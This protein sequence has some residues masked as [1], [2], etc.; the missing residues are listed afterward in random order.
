MK[1]LTYL[2]EEDWKDGRKGKI[3][4]SKL[5]DIV[6]LR[7]DGKKVGYWQL[8]ADRLSIDPD[9]E[10]PMERGHRLEEEAIARFTKET[11]KEVD[12]SLVILIRDDDETIAVSPDGIISEYEQI[13]VK[14]LKSAKH[15]EAYFTQKVPKEYYYQTLQYFI[16]NDSLETLHV[17]MYDPRVLVKDYFTLEIRRQDMQADVDQ[18]LEYERQTLKEINDMA[19]K[20]TFDTL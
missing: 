1:I 4:G 8:L 10:Y 7:G 5:G 3:T 14:C 9:E 16:V 12:T 19:N 15:L 20:L 17:V 2:T 18:F 6:T 11:S 13:E